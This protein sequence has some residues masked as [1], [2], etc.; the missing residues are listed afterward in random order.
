MF[1]NP[2]K[3]SNPLLTANKIWDKNIG[4]VVDRQ[5]IGRGGYDRDV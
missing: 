3:P 5:K 1:G 4:F 2:R